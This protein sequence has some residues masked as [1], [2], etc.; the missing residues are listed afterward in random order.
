MRERYFVGWQE[1]E[2]LQVGGASYQHEIYDGQAAD[3]QK[4]LATAETAED[5]ARL[6]AL[7]NEYEAVRRGAM[8]LHER[9]A[10][11]LS[12]HGTG[13]LSGHLARPLAEL[14]VTLGRFERAEQGRKTL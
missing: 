3:P 1:P 5:A 11:M 9:A 6:A 13:F 14:G 4:P 12:E 10:H 7:L 8:W 2:G